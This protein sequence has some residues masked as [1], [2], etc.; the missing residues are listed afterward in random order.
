MQSKERLT[1]IKTHTPN[2]YDCMVSGH[3]LRITDRLYDGDKVQGV[4]WLE[5]VLGGPREHFT[6]MTHDH[7]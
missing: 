2:R 7:R 4:G 5:K 3:Q 1:K 6:W